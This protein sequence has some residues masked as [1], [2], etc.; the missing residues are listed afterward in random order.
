MA[1]IKRV[2]WSSVSPQ[3]IEGLLAA[4][5]ASRLPLSAFAVSKG[6]SASGFRSA[7]AR[8]FPERMR[9][10]LAAKARKTPP[11]IRGRA[12]EYRVR[13]DLQAR[14]FMVLRSPAS[15]G[16]ADL[17]AIAN[18]KNLLVQVKSGAYISPEE[19]KK[20]VT[21]AASIGAQPILAERSDGRRLQY[22][23]IAEGTERK[24]FSPNAK[25]V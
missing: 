16:A 13:N 3:A 8:L 24:E 20:L 2:A 4:F 10:A 12:L 22:W 21:L 11:G 25:S 18:G 19:R 9:A 5:E 14:G 7:A 6:I 1:T 15:K 17:V 23:I